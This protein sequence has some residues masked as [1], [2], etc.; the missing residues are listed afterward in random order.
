MYPTCLD[1][2]REKKTKTTPNQTKP[3]ERNDDA[4]ACKNERQ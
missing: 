1:A 4:D 2:G 3:R